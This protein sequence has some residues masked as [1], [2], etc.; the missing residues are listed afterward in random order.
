MKH[1]DTLGN[2]KYNTYK[3]TNDYKKYKTH[4][5]RSPLYKL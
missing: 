3:T 2:N 5:V 4:E 1:S